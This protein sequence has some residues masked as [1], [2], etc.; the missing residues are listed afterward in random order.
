MVAGRGDG[1]ELDSPERWVIEN[2]RDPISFFRN[3]DLLIPEDSILYFEA[4]NI[5]PEV[6]RFYESNRAT[7]GTVCVARDMVYPV[8][9]IFH[10][11]MKADVTER[12]TELLQKHSL[13]NCFTHLKAYRQETLLVSFHDAFDGSDLR[14][15]DQIPSERM[16]AFCKKLGSSF[17]RERND[18][19]RNT[20]VLQTLLR[21]MENPEEVRILWPWWKRA[22]LFWKK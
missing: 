14:V 8:P 16:E 17:R 5:A 6:A 2:L 15:S 12:L 10:V 21:A 18:N 20:E 1:I 11:P 22:L 19:N 3:L 9:E 7:V 13:E 4:I